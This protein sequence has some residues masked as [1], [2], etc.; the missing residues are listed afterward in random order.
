MIFH[1]SPKIF[2]PVIRPK[3]TFMHKFP[4]IC[5]SQG[6]YAFQYEVKAMIQAHGKENDSLSNFHEEH[7]SKVLYVIAQ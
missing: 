1:G 5:L 3:D 7:I 4:F 6:R 2:L